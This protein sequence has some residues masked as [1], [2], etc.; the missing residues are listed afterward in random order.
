MLPEKEAVVEEEVAEV[1]GAAGSDAEAD[2]CP[3]LWGED[4]PKR[5]RKASGRVGTCTQL[6]L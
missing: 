1:A 2:K 3:A 6:Y 4:G 5:K